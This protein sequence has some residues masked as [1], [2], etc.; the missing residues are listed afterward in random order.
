MARTRELEST[1]FLPNLDQA[2]GVLSYKNLKL[3]LVAPPIVPVGEREFKDVAEME[4]FMHSEIVIRIHPTGDKSAPPVVAVGC[5]GEHVW[6]P[7][8]RAISIPR[9]FV[10]NLA[11]YETAYSTERNRDPNSDEG[12]VQRTAANQPFP[13]T[14]IRDGHPKGRAWLERIMVGG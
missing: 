7:R 2:E 1:D 5:N 12:M 6:L 3:T 9:K 11:R 10:E 14:V 13:F 8:G 4:A